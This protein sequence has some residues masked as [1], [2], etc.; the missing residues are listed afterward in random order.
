LRSTLV[1]CSLEQWLRRALEYRSAGLD[2]LLTSQSPLGEV[3]ACPSAPSLDG[4]AACLL[5]V[6]DAERLRRLETR[7]PGRWNQDARDRCVGWAR[8]HRA[9]AADPRHV[10][11]VL[12]TGGWSEMAWHR[13]SSWARDDPRWTVTVVD[14]TGRTVTE[15]ATEIADWVATARSR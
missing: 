6:A 4:I 5:D 11:E 3:L 14:T 15:T 7:D 9:H 8:W 13:W 10:P 12:T 1:R 2:L